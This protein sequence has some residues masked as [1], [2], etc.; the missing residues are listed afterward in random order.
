MDVGRV[1]REGG[2]GD[3]ERVVWTTTTVGHRVMQK[4]GVRA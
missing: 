1:V 2:D 4:E 3:A